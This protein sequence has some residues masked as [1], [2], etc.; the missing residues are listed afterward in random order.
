MIPVFLPARHRVVAPNLPA[1]MRARPS[2][3]AFGDT[4][5]ESG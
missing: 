3:H 4:T 2:S 1:G 5:A